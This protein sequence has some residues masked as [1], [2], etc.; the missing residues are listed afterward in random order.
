VVASVVR[1]T[2]SSAGSLP[3]RLSARPLPGHVPAI[4]HRARRLLLAA[5]LNRLPA[6]AVAWL[7]RPATGSPVREWP[8]RTARQL[9]QHGGVPRTV[10]RFRLVDNPHLAFVNADSMVTQ[11]LFWSGE[12]GWEPELLPWWRFFCRRSETILELGANVGY[13]SVQGAVCAPQARYVAV[14]PHPVSLRTC[15]E[16]LALNGIR[17]VRLLAAA[18]SADPAQSTVPL[19]VPVAQLG[20]PTVAFLAEGSELPRRMAGPV[21]TTVDVEA[22]DVRSLLPGVDLLKLDVEGQEHALLAAG[23]EQLRAQRPTIFVEVLPGTPRLRALLSRLCT[24][25]GY[26][27]YV[28]RGDHLVPVPPRRLATVDLQRQYGTNDVL[29][30]VHPVPPA[31]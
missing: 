11:Q 23:W 5:V 2:G 31:A 15:R 9:L 29:L 4:A 7:R 28:P 6:T 26:R 1:G 3:V 20:T 18:A 21:R 10:R 30:S 13:F 27:C 24:E 17:T 25:L 12:Q 16:N 14:E 8:R 19:V 22:V